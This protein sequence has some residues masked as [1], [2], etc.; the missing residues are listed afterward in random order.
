LLK[1]VN[2]LNAES[3]NL[4]LYEEGINTTDRS[5]MLFEITAAFAKF[6]RD[7][8]IER[9]KAGHAQARRKGTRSGRAIGRPKV[10]RRTEERIRAGL[11]KGIGILKLARQL[12]VG[13]SVVQ[14]IKQEA[15]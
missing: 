15:A 13:T 7:L 11:A 2:T 5:D 1:T 9:V 8:I 4:V 10:N 3:V 12:G 6:E 14:R